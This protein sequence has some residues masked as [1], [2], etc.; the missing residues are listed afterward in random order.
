MKWP[1]TVLAY[2]LVNALMPVAEIPGWVARGWWITAG[3]EDWRSVVDDPEFGPL[4][5]AYAIPQSWRDPVT[6]YDRPSLRRD[7]VIIASVAGK[8]PIAAEWLSHRVAPISEY[9]LAAAKDATANPQPGI[10][11]FDDAIAETRRPFNDH[12]DEIAYRMARV[13]GAIRALGDRI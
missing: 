12:A 10:D 11:P 6:P 1:M 4:G 9:V 8:N 3:D 13:D 2:E 7:A 5:G